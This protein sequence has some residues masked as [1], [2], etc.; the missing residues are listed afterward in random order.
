M[1]IHKFIDAHAKFV[2]SS[3][4]EKLLA[5]DTQATARPERTNPENAFPN[6][7]VRPTQTGSCTGIAAYSRLNWRSGD[8]RERSF[9]APEVSSLWSAAGTGILAVGHLTQ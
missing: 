5:A 4:S 2:F 1:I 6:P 8:H 3:H 9:I 7:R